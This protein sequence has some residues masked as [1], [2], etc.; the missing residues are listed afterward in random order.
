MLAHLRRSVV[1]SVFFFILC[2]LI[3][4]F[5][6]TGLSQLF[7][8]HQANGSLTANGSTII[9][10]NWSG[11]QWFQGRPSAAGN[12]YDPTASGAANL[13]PRSKALEQAVAKQAAALQKEGIAPT[14]GLVT[15]SGSGLDPD[16]SPADAYTQVPAVAAAH[17]LPVTAVHQLVAAHVHGAQLGFLG[18]PYVNVLELNEALAGQTGK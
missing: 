18:A 13:G 1:I 4:P 5:A 3:Y 9:G 14:N 6:G 10:Q 17:H 12:G 15:S 7:F 8:K 16:I 2:G 11:P